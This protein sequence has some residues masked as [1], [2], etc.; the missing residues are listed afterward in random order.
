MR[1]LRQR[2]RV[3]VTGVTTVRPPITLLGFGDEPRES[4]VR[5]AVAARSATKVQ[6]AARPREA[7]APEL[8]DD[9]VELVIRDVGQRLAGV[10]GELRQELLRGHYLQ[11]A[12]AVIGK[13]VRGGRK[14]R[15]LVRA[16][17]LGRPE[18]A[19]LVEFAEGPALGPSGAW[20]QGFRGVIQEERAGLVDDRSGVW[21]M[22]GCLSDLHQRFVRL[23]QVQPAEP[24][25]QRILQLF[26]QLAEVEFE[27][28][29][30]GLDSCARL[31]L[32]NDHSRPLMLQL[33]MEM[34]R[35]VA[36]GRHADEFAR[37][38]S[39]GLVHWRRWQVFLRRGDVEMDAGSARRAMGPLRVHGT[40]F[41]ERNQRWFGPELAL[42]WT[43]RIACAQVGADLGVYLRDV[44]RLM[45][46]EG[47]TSWGAL[48]PLAWRGARE[49]FIG[50]ASADAAGGAGRIL[51]AGESPAA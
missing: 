17:Y 6:E 15:S 18:G 26:D 32:R 29:R 14:S 46:R 41:M 50:V 13:R 34:A 33:Q 9:L 23:P 47:E 42:V 21:E 22:A 38:C 35:S 10:R 4:R 28:Q 39:Y 31:A 49:P 5:D 2:Q 43:L 3:S 48:T 40:S 45:D 30:Q 16:W 19:A 12:E 44:L 24:R 8:A 36:A 51:P 27:A 25:L 1:P 37:T 11:V 7:E 20:L